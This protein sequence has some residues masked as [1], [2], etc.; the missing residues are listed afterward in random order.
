MTPRQTALLNYHRDV[1]SIGTSAKTPVFVILDLED[2]A[3]FEI[4]SQF[5]PNCADR[6]DAIRSTGSIPAFT[7]ALSVADANRFIAH[8]WPQ[9]K[10]ISNPPPEGM[11]PVLLVSEGRCLSILLPKTSP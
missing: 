7:L 2:R 11:V 4:A 6:R 8:G 1:A 5:Q 10:R 9:M 3:G